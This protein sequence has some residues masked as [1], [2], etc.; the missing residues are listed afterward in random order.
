[1]R[2]LSFLLAVLL[3]GSTGL[4]GCSKSEFDYRTW[5]A[6]LDDSEQ[7]RERAV[8][9]LEQLGNPDAIPALGEAWEDAGKPVR[10]LQVIISLARP[11]TPEDAKKAFVTDYETSGR[12][13]SWDAALPFLVK[14]ISEIDEANPRSVDSATKAAEALGE[15]Q[16]A[17]GMDALIELGTKPVTK[18]LY[19]AQI[20]AVRAIG[21]YETDKPRAGAALVKIVDREGPPHPKTAKG[22][23]QQ[24][25][26]EEKYGLY[27]AITGA[28]IN[29]LGDLRVSTAA[30]T[31]VLAMYRVSPLFG[32]VRRALVASGPTAKDEMRKILRGE[33]QQVNQLFKDKKLD[34][35]CGDAG[36]RTTECVPVSAKDYYPAVVLGDFYDPASAPDLLA[37]LKRPALPVYYQD[38]APSDFTQHGAIYDSLRKIGAADAAATVRASW[39]TKDKNPA[40]YAERA[41]AASAYAF[42]VRDGAGAT[43]L[44]AIAGDNAIEGRDGE[45]LRQEAAT[46]F[47]RI[48]RS[49]AD[50]KVLKGLATKYLEAAG[51]KKAEA[52]KL[53]EAADKADA[54]LAVLKKKWDD[55]KIAL[56]KLSKSTTD[57]AAS[58]EKLKAFTTGVNKLE[59][60]YKALKKT[61]REATQPYKDA[62]LAVKDYT[63]FARMFLTH[64]ARLEPGIRCADNLQCF[65]DA[66]KLTPEQAEKNLAPYLAG[67]AGDKLADW[68]KEQK[69]SILDANIERAM[70]ELGKR[71]QAASQFTDLLLDNAKRKERLVRQSILLALPKIAKLPCANCEAKLDAVI[72]SGEGDAGLAELNTETTM[73]RNYFGWAGGKTPTPTKPADGA[74]PA[75]APAK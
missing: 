6:K 56:I 41:M 70:L 34:Q 20:A 72:K 71:G 46:A 29:A 7:E 57:D 75:Q 13:A 38:D 55:D 9:K 19:P 26:Y 18:K 8:D 49:D 54:T 61:T 39:D 10:M 1:M 65:A 51:K 60:D 50:I 64:V 43:E 21:K 48:G 35:Y 11:L 30:P 68:T 28:S 73:M 74:P 31:L 16:L 40:L 63:A 67:F 58:V 14:A 5:T 22:K 23:E 45:R 44:A 47:A 12:K 69:L 3:A 53:K 33:N 15:S 17:G 25:A 37:A 52:A 62:D 66:L 32:Q 2:Q 4:A 42:L 24:R 59:A 36:D 27:L